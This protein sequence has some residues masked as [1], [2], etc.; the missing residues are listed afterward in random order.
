MGCQAHHFRPR[1][2]CR[3]LSGGRTGIYLLWGTFFDENGFTLDAFH[4]AFGEP[5]SLQTIWNSAAFS[6]GGACVAM[7]FGTALAYLQARTDVPMKGLLFAASLM[8]LILPPIVYAIAWVF[9]YGGD[10]GIVSGI[11]VRIFGASPVDAY[12]LMGMIMASGL[13][14]VPDGVPLHGSRI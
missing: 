10:V 11:F 2:R 1:D 8:P 4:R 5:E 13:H 14:L 9:L 7:F 12:G 6:V 3:R